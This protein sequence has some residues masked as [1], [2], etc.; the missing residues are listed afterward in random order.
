MSTALNT[1]ATVTQARKPRG[2][3][4]SR[5][6]R[7]AFYAIFA[8]CFGG[9]VAI[10]RVEQY[11]AYATISNARHALIVERNAEAVAEIEAKVAARYAAIETDAAQ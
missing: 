5:R 4:G 3:W 11:A 7:I 8:V 10:D 1:T 2:K 9:A 6:V